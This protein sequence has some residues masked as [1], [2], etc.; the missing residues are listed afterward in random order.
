MGR[1]DEL[2]IENAQ[3]DND[4]KDNP[5]VKLNMIAYYGLPLKWPDD[6][7]FGTICILDNNENAFK[8]EY[9]ELIYEFKLA[10]ERDLELIC[11][12]QKL[13]YYAE[14]DVITSSYNRG[15]IEAILK[16]EFERAKRYQTTF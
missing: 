16:S 12:Q 7:F 1:N 15:K 11:D 4:W 8:S 10:L 6:E 2:L 5:D 14:M 9:K 3:K 13:T